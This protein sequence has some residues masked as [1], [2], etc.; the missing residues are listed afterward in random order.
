MALKFDRAVMT[1]ELGRIKYAVFTPGGREQ[2]HIRIWLDGPASE[3]N[4]VLKVDYQLHPTF[5]VR[6]RSSEDRNE[7][8]AISIWTWGMFPI[9]TR[10][11][12]RGGKIEEG[13]FYLTYDLSPDLNNYVKVS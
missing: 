1:D 12:F 2:Y 4:N 11:Y 3:L 5:A 10:I 9:K 6:E 8:F 7:K 13:Q